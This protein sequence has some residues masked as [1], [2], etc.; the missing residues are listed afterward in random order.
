MKNDDIELIQSSLIGDENAFAKLVRK[1]QK[2][3]HALA[4]RKVGDFHVAEEITQDTF[5]RV[6]KKLST[7]KDPGR[8]AGWLYRIAARQCHAWLRK[9]RIQ[10]QALEDTDLE[11]I[12]GGT[13]SQY[14]AEEQEKAATE[15][16]R[17]IVQ[18]LLA[19]LRESERTVVTLHYF[20]EMTTEEISRFLG[21]SASTVKS[22]LRRA[23]LRLKK[24]EPMIREAL[25]GFQIRANLT[26]KIMQEISRIAPT[27]PSSGKPFVPWAIAASSL[28]L[29]VMALGASSQY[30]TRFQQPYNF[31]APSEMT[32]ELIDAPIVLNLASKP[33][34]RTQPGKSEIT[35]RGKGF[36]PSMD[37]QE[38]VPRF[39][40]AQAKNVV[41]NDDKP[42]QDIL[43]IFQ[44]PAAGYQDYT[45]VEIDTTAFKDGG[46]LTID[47]WIGSAEAAGAFI[48]FASDSELST[49]GMPEVV[50]TS[51][52][53]IV[54]GKGGR[55]SHRFDKG[56]RFKLGATGNSFS[57]NGKVNSFLATISIDAASEKL[58]AP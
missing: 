24:A 13:Y 40:S 53:G 2:Q 49:D 42:S 32:V 27:P 44:T 38:Y 17:D 1:Y 4:W 19:R 3:V 7:L 36:A 50:L 6:Y 33:D 18:R 46:M 16:Q 12:E 43:S 26:E 52:S 20:G 11:L 34:V 56:R 23:R 9:K 58:D 5:L 14:I 8:F 48:L 47:L 45:I 21:V 54:P 41:L 10:T 30:L 28:I 22:R 25:E 35:S 29:V 31:D 51:A 37:Q 57:G 55:L 15:A 39:L